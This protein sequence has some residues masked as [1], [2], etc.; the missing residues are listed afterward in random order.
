MWSRSRASIV[1]VDALRAADVQRADAALVVG[2]DRDSG[3]DALDLVVGEAVGDEPLAGAA[4]DQLLRAR[5]GGHPLRLDPGQGA[6]AALGGDGGAE[7]GVDLLGRE[8]RGGR[9][10]GLRVAGGDPDL[11]AQAL[12]ALADLL[13]D[14]AGELPRRAASRRGRRRRSPR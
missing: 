10:H 2:R 7:Q 13:G 1:G 6:G 4:G 12:L 11:G 8:A 14:V 5:A 9:R 3:E